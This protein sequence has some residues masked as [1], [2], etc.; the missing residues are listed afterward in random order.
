MSVKSGKASSVNST[1]RDD[2]NWS[3]EWRV[4]ALVDTS[5]M[6]KSLFSSTVVGLG[7]HCRVGAKGESFKAARG[8]VAELLQTCQ[9]PCF[10]MIHNIST[11]IL[12]W[13]KIRV[14][15]ADQALD[16]TGAR[17]TEREVSVSSSR[18]RR[19]PHRPPPRPPRPQRCAAWRSPWRRSASCRPRHATHA[20]AQLRTQP[21]CDGVC[22]VTDEP[23]RV[24]LAAKRMLCT[25]LAFQQGEREATLNN[26]IHGCSGSV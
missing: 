23:S 13:F 1:T 26:L 21:G 7:L 14:L 4:G 15:R 10:Q 2:K 12:G 16:R 22:Q 8:S 5:Q 11:Y 17:A 3:E 20:H 6:R 9:I 18:T 24:S 19:I 25:C